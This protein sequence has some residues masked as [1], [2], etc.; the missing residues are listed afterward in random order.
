MWITVRVKTTVLSTMLIVFV[1]I[2]TFGPSRQG[3]SVRRTDFVKLIEIMKVLVDDK[4]D[5]G[6]DVTTLL[7]DV[8]CP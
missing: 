2:I 6:D 4:P 3:N 1:V 7:K 8:R 5:S